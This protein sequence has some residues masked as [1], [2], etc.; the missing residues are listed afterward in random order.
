[1]TSVSELTSVLRI[2]FTADCTF[3]L[4]DTHAPSHLWKVSFKISSF[5]LWFFLEDGAVPKRNQLLTY[6]A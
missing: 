2:L 6:P 1:M 5:V 4:H 3:A